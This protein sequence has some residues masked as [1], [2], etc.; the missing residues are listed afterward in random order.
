MGWVKQAR[1]SPVFARR[2]A[3]LMHNDGRQLRQDRFEPV[4]EPPGQ[5]LA[6]G[7]GEVRQFVEIAMIE[8]LHERFGSGFDLAVVDEV[9]QF[10]ID[11]A[12]DDQIKP[13]RMPMQAAALVLGRKRGQI[14]G[15]FKSETFGE[16]DKHRGD[17]SV[18][19]GWREMRNERRDA[20]T[21]RRNSEWI[22]W[23][24]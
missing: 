7:V 16:A 21:P 19:R 5:I 4:P 1:L 9:A 8:L 17:F 14:V 23:F 2:S 3:G 24:F 13:E 18:R 20:K 6:G 10:G 11:V 12:F 22:V 15:S